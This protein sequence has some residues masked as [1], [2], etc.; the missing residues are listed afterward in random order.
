MN[1]ESRSIQVNM[2]LDEFKSMI[3]ESVRE[4]FLELVGEDTS[5]EPN[6]TVAIAD[7]L[8]NYQREKPV[9]IPVDDVVKELGLDA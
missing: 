1:K 5:S 3:R 4:V 9:G 7:R 8:R 2:S 6:F